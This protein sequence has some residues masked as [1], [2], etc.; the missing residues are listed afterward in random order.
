MGC[1]LHGIEHAQP[2][3]DVPIDGEYGVLVYVALVGYLR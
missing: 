2:G 3:C 1:A